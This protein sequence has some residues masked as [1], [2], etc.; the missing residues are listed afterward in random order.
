M[1]TRYSSFPRLYQERLKEYDRALSQAEPLDALA[2]A[3]IRNVGISPTGPMERSFLSN[4][5][6]MMD[7][8]IETLRDVLERLSPPVSPRLKE[9]LERRESAIKLREAVRVDGGDISLKSKT[10]DPRELE[11]PMR[12]DAIDYLGLQDIGSHSATGTVPTTCPNESGPSSSALVM[13]NEQQGSTHVLTD[14]LLQPC[15]STPNVQTTTH[16]EP[17]D[18]RKHKLP[19]GE[20]QSMKLDGKE[21]LRNSPVQNASHLRQSQPVPRSVPR[22]ISKQV[23]KTESLTSRITDEVHPSSKRGPLASLFTL[24]LW[25]VSEKNIGYWLLGLIL[26]GVVMAHRAI[27]PD[28]TPVYDQ[29]ARKLTFAGQQCNGDC[30]GQVAGYEWAKVHFPNSTRDCDGHSAAFFL[31]CKAWVDEAKAWDVERRYDEEHEPD[32]T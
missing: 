7:A 17:F 4:M 29:R 15:V 30:S 5:K 10:V 25:P 14:G 13:V 2:S 16:N 28:T 20:L 18:P 26:L 24:P 21:L 3:F 27:P 22:L 19:D 23:E 6:M 11:E 32:G 1:E 9:W 8:T 31:G 12:S